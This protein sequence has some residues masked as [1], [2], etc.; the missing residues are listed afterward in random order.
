MLVPDPDDEDAEA[1]VAVADDVAVY[2]AGLRGLHV[3]PVRFPF[4]L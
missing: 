4:D 2:P 1:V 3:P